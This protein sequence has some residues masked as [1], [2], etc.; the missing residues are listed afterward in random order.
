MSNPTLN[1]FY[2]FHF[3]FPFI[4]LILVVLHLIF[5]H[6][7]GSNNPRGSN[8]NLDKIIFYP[9]FLFKDLLLLLIT[10]ILFLILII[11]YPTLL[12]DPENFILANP[13]ITPIHI[14]PE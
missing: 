10:V 7:T 1:R 5:L 13:L 14:Q 8:S 6:N 12:G 4:I 2:T 11:Q 9:Y 3:I